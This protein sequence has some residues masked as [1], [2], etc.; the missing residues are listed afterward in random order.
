MVL[1]LLLGAEDLI[2]GTRFFF[3]FFCSSP[4]IVFFLSLLCPTYGS[5]L[6]SKFNY[7]ISFDFPYAALPSFFLSSKIRSSSM[8]WW[9]SLTKIHVTKEGFMHGVWLAHRTWS[10][11]ADGEVLVASKSGSVH[12]P[13]MAGFCSFEDWLLVHYPDVALVILPL[14]LWC[15]I[16]NTINHQADASWTRLSP[17]EHQEGMLNGC[18]DRNARISGDIFGGSLCVHKIMQWSI[19]YLGLCGRRL[20]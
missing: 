17:S 3:F 20:L 14:P 4:T 12:D 16:W 11:P 2:A 7:S 6:L 15:R 9:T 10:K 1:V 19:K 5:Y 8:S 13:E 18:W